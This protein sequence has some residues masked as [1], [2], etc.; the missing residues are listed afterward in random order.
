MDAPDRSEAILVRLEGLLKR[1]GLTPFSA[2]IAVGFLKQQ[3]ETEGGA[4]RMAR[5]VAYLLGQLNGTAAA[6]TTV[7]DWQRGCPNRLLGLRSMPFWP[8]EAFSWLPQLE[9][10][11]PDILREFLAAKSEGA[12]G[13]FQ[14]YRSPRSSAS[15]SSSSQKPGDA[16]GEF[17]TDSGSWNV[18]Y[19]QLHGMDFEASMA[20]FPRTVEAVQRLVPRPY[21]HTFLSALSGG[22][23]ITPHY[24]PT[25]KKL[26]LHLPLLVPDGGAWLRV[27]EQRV[28]LARGRAIIFDDSHE[29][30]TALSPLAL[31]L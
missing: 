30:R 3:L 28:Q 1:L 20:R 13:L 31:P 19:L 4:H 14:P 21:N 10:C 26:R 17:A 12:E 5:V 15:S 25:N 16:L 22:A 27:A 11:V 9:Q 2:K 23:H 8:R 6:P 18:C 29:V 7:V 24:G